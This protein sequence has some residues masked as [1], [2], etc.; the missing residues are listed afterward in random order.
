MFDWVL[1]SALV[2]RGTNSGGRE[3]CPCLFL[4]IEN[5]ALILEKNAS[6]MSLDMRLYSCGL[7]GLFISQKMKIFCQEPFQ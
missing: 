3:R 1:N 6:K 7:F 2:C 4:R 5:S